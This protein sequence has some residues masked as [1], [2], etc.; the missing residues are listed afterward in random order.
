MRILVLAFLTAGWA[1][2]TPATVGY[3][4][5]QHQD[6]GV[7]WFTVGVLANNPD[8]PTTSNVQLE[9][10]K[11]IVNTD[12][13]GIFEYLL[14]PGTTRALTQPVQEPGVKWP[15]SL[16]QTLVAQDDPT[17]EYHSREFNPLAA[18]SMNA[19][20]LANAID[21]T[22]STDRI[23]QARLEYRAV[24]LDPAWNINLYPGPHSSSAISTIHTCTAL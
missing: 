9:D 21:G 19:V 4:A 23:V 14:T 7:G 6:S 8:N 5:W 20:C 1:M 12:L 3:F 24:L 10:V 22:R 2:S 13:G 16:S 15:G 11:L 17:V 18:C